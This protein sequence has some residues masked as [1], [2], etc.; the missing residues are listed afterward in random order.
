MS[1]HLMREV[2]GEYWLNKG[3]SFFADKLFDRKRDR[4][5]HG[6]GIERKNVPEVQPFPHVDTSIS[7]SVAKSAEP[8]V[9]P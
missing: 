7:I 5:N 9:M 8:N 4:W 2:K 6:R 1:N 3:S